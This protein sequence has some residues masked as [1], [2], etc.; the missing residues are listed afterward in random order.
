MG[1]TVASI[2]LRRT[3]WQDA[4]A[5]EFRRRFG[6]GTLEIWRETAPSL[7]SISAMLHSSSRAFAL[8]TIFIGLFS[9]YGFGQ[10][11]AVVEM[12]GWAT[13]L[14]TGG[15]YKTDAERFMSEFSAQQLNAGTKQSPSETKILYC[16]VGQKRGK[17][18]LENGDNF[19]GTLAAWK[20]KPGKIGQDAGA[21]ES[22]VDET[23]K[24]LLRHLTENT[25]D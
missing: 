9:P 13:A 4:D 7:L 3:V 5:I 14:Q 1:L 23:S 24:K 20:A 2:R 22:E 16:L 21:L 25:C 17:K 12:P 8:A 6:F 10:Q 15:K 11:L 18:I 19:S